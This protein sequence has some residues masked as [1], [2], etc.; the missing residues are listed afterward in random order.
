MNLCK[1]NI[2]IAKLRV[3]RN[4]HIQYEYF[5]SGHISTLSKIS[6]YNMN[7]CHLHTLAFFLV[8]NDNNPLNA[9]HTDLGIRLCQNQ[10]FATTFGG[11]ICHNQV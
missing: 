9:L 1:K 7:I 3:K 2:A 8:R 11:S 10:R 6:L 4:I 5:I